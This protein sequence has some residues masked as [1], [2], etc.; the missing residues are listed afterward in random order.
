MKTKTKTK[1][2]TRAMNQRKFRSYLASNPKVWRLFETFTFDRIN[3]GYLQYSADSILHRIRW[4]APV[5]TTYEYKINNNISSYMARHFIRKHP[6]HAG[7]FELR[8][9]TTKG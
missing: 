4:E 5:K 3:K 9:Q 1:T 6:N 8:R 2:K 7:F